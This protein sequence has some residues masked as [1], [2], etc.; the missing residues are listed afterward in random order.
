MVTTL[1]VT[2]IVPTYQA[3]DFLAETLATVA[4]QTKLPR[5]LIVIDDGST[6]STCDIVELFV[7]DHPELSVRL[8]QEPH[9]GPGAARNA[10][11]RAACT[12]WVA[13]L[14]SDDLWHPEKIEKMMGAVQTHFKANFFC[15][16][17]T[18]RLLNGTER[19]M[20]YSDG[21]LFDKPIHEQLYLRNYFSTSA[22]VCRRDMVLRWGGFDESLSSAQDYELWIKMSPDLVPVFVPEVLG[23]YVFRKGNITTSRFWKRLIN[24]LRVKHRHRTKGGL[25]LYAYCIARDTSLHFA[26]LLPLG[27]KR[28]LKE[29]LNNPRKSEG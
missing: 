1:N 17:E 18:I 12:E 29:A 2:V 28:A 13:F 10:G 23:T 4:N 9:R 3:E 27:F 21:F 16:N 5:E 7:T 19:V 26:T 8:L 11:V 6:D 24:I 15:H 20:D 14:D 25:L 22:T